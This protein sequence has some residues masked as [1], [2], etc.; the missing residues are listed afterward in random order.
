MKFLLIFMCYKILFFFFFL[1][2]S[3]Q[4]KNS[5]PKGSINL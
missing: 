1:V 2:F 5:N 3:L 4:L